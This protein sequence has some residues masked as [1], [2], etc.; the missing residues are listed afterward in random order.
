VLFF[1]FALRGFEG[2]FFGYQ[3]LGI[4]FATSFYFLREKGVAFPFLCIMGGSL[5][6]S[7]G[8]GSPLFL[9]FFVDSGMSLRESLLVMKQWL[10]SSPR[11]FFS[12]MRKIKLLI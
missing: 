7:G 11:P 4:P 8:E 1:S 10:H 5:S 9:L 12:W 6:T 3:E 2:H